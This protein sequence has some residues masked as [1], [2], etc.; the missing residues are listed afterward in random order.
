MGSE[1]FLRLLVFLGTV[2]CATGLI[3]S[4]FAQNMNNY[5]G[6]HAPIPGN[7]QMVRVQVLVYDSVESGG[8]EIQSANFNQTDIS[9]KPR[10]IHGFRGEAA[11][12]VKPGTYKLKWKVQRD[13]FIWPRVIP[14][15][16]TVKI[17]PRDLWLQIT[18]QGENA[19]IT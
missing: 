13:K 10:D 11:F 8:L 14:H 12:Q 1:R 4:L 9:L 15:E 19:V 5:M 3:F 16:E 18:I 17:D 2:F 6:P 7:P